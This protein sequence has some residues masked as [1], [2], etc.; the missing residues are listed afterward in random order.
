MRTTIDNLDARVA[1]FFVF[2]AILSKS[3]EPK[4]QIAELE[5]LVKTIIITIV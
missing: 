4:N 3:D 1:L 2:K 5:N